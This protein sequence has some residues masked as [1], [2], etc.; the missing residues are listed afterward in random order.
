MHIVKNKL[1]ELPGTLA[2]IK[3]ILD[4]LRRK[5][6]ESE[7]WTIKNEEEEEDKKKKNKNDKNEEDDEENNGLSD[8]EYDGV[9]K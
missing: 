5:D 7:I 1:R 6:E 4:K 9:L 2:K 3:D 8:E